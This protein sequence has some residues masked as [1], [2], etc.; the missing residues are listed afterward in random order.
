MGRGILWR[1][2]AVAAVAMAAPATAQQ[3]LSDSSTFIKAVRDRDG[4]KAQELLEKPGSNII[5][6]RDPKTGET[7][8]HIA[9]K[10]RD[11]T[12]VQY[13]LAKGAPV[14]ARDQQGMTA[15]ADAAQLDWAE[16]VTQLIAQGAKVDATDDHGETPLILATQ[17]RSVPVVHL[18]LTNGADPRA[19]D[20]VAGM[21]AIDYATRDGRMP[22][23]LRLLQEA[24]PVVKKNVSG[25]SINGR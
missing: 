8:L 19:T 3:F 20:S 25:P 1:T 6:S 24:K 23:V 11:M 16:G 17:A 12:W 14:D 2:A 9:T 13:M 18:L 4:A 10:R 22:A 5:L 7:A 15:L 21:S